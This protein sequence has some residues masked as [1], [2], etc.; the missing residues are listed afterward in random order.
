MHDGGVGEFS[1]GGGR[2]GGREG[3]RER[4]RERKEVKKMA[5]YQKKGRE[6]PFIIC[7]KT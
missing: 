2:E 6:K 5:R 7:R 3:E 1:L 4:E